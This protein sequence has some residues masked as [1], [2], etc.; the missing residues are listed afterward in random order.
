MSKVTA[1]IIDTTPEI[2]EQ[3]IDSLW[4][5]R[6]LSENTLSA[7]RTDIKN[8]NSCLLKYSVSL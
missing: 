3:F 7:Y 8:F 5:E 1:E 4:M 2:I 6:G